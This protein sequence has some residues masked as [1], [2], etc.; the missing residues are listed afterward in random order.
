MN[1]PPAVN[2]S[3]RHY[4]TEGRNRRLK[5][6]VICPDCGQSRFMDRRNIDR[7]LKNGSFTGRCWDCHS[8]LKGKLSGNWRGGRHLGSSGRYVYLTVG[9]DHP[10]VCMANCRNEI[11]EHRL[12]MARHLGRPLHRDE[13]VHH[14]DGIRTNNDPDNLLVLDKKEH[15]R[16]E[17]LIRFGKMKREEVCN[18]AYAT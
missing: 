11:A 6:E 2:W 5:I 9:S 3:N 7:P 1:Y 8:H 13:H 16:I 10:F 17:Q 12:V 14:R 4:V 15:H 18:H